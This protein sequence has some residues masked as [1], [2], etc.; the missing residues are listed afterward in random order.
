MA[1]V[2]S[3]ARELGLLVRGLK[4]LH[5]D[6]VRERRRSAR[7][8]RRARAARHASTSAAADAASSL[9]AAL[10]LDLSSVSRQVAALEREGWVLREPDPADSRAALLELTPPAA[11]PC[12]RVRTARVDAPARRL[13]D[14]TGRRARRPSPPRCTASA[15]T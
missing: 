2:E 9:A 15:P 13:P 1:P 8:A 12:A 5:T 11:T 14:W 6:S 4:G 7:R 3:V 10:H